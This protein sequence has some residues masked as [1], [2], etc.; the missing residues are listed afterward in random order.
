L[1]GRS[2]VETLLSDQVIGLPDNNMM[3][4]MDDAL[5][6]AML[7]DQWLW[8][9][10]E[11]WMMMDDALLTAMLADQWLWLCRE[12]WISG[13]GGSKPYRKHDDDG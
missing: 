7:A 5:L 8:L 2:E 13:N 3:M 4:M 12:A 1:G 6:T 9:C 11:A 10:R